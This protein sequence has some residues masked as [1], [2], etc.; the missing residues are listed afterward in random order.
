MHFGPL[1][2]REVILAD[3][4]FGARPGEAPEPICLVARSLES[5]TVWRL[6]RDELLGRT[7]A[8]YPTDDD[9][10]FVA[11]YASAEIGCHRALGW[12]VPKNVLDLFTEFRNLTNG[13]EVPCGNGL[14]GA[15]AWFGQDSITAADKETMRD[16]ALRGGPWTPSEQEELV[17]YCQRD[18]DAV[19]RLLPKLL[20]SIDVPLA[21]LRGRYMVAAAHMEAVGIPLDVGSHRIVVRHWDTIKNAL[22]DRIDA[23][24]NVYQAGV[25]KRDRFVAYLKATGI[26]WPLLQSGQPRLDDDTFR[27]MARLHPAVAPL[28]ELRVSLSQLRLSDLAIGPDGRNRCLL[29]A[30]QSRT[31]R[32][33]PS[34][35]QFVFG[36]AVWLRSLIR[37]VPGSALAYIDWAQQ[38]FGIAAALSGDAAMLAAYVSGD[39]YLTF[40][41]QAGAAPPTATKQTHE[42][43]REQFKACA[44]AVQYGMEEV[45]LG[46]RIGQSPGRARELLHLHRKTYY[47]FWQWSDASLDY[48]LL[49]NHLY[50]A[51]GWRLHVGPS[52]NPR[53][54]RNF[55]MQANGAEMLRLA[56]CFATEEGISVCAPVHDAILIEAPVGDIDYIVAKTQRAMAEAS[57]IV[58]GGLELRSEA[59][60]IRYPD[61]YIDPR[62]RRMWETVQSVIAEQRQSD[63][64]MDA[65]VPTQGRSPAPSLSISLSRR[66]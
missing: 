8:P 50:T 46:Q 7:E 13:L 27:E 64:C 62:G 42:A 44:L 29:S 41:K 16:L 43:I 17:E 61:R 21:L 55:P 20:P 26:S 56:C 5:G 15:L 66:N 36:L 51:F 19:S 60:V 14:L 34:T 30:F 1:T 45:S 23:D 18:V 48:A 32:N 40:A 57:R 37:P 35:S 4:E 63:Q 6:W 52:A 47:R 28:R 2:F 49:R 31:G 54:I 11:Y 3:F 22:I 53:S 24:Y 38:E 9:T 33:Q 10:L 12:P 65:T 58:L 39:P 59:T 25:F